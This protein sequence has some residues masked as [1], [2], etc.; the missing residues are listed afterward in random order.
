MPIGSVTD[1]GA[2]ESCVE[3]NLHPR[4]I[5]RVVNDAA[6][7]GAVGCDEL[8]RQA[9][10]D[11][12]AVAVLCRPHLEQRRLVHQDLRHVS[13]AASEPGAGHATAGAWFA[14]DILCHIIH[15]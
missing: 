11:T 8:R 7:E 14:L 13:L 12:V 3:P 6:T 4:D 10:A 15:I 1:N 2:Q 9:G 5:G